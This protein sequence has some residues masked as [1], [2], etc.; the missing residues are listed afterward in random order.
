[1]S[2]GWDV[3][4]GL[5]CFTEDHN[6][7]H[8]SVVESRNQLQ[9]LLVSVLAGRCLL[10]CELASIAS[11]HVAIQQTMWWLQSE[12]DHNSVHRLTK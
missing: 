9:L 6:S 7:W 5:R 10:Q 1:M 8:G 11:Y 4:V 2:V 3:Q 12:P